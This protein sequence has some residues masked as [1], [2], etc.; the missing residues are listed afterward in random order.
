[1]RIEKLMKK[2]IVIV[3]SFAVINSTITSSV[4]MSTLGLYNLYNTEDKTNLTVDDTNQTEEI[5]NEN[6][7]QTQP[8]GVLYFKIMQ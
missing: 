4:A 3:L 5:A 8:G 2:I 1:M 7:L 6:T